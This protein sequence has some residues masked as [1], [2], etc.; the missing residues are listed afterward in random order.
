MKP[1]IYAH[2]GASA[3]APENTM[4]AFYEAEKRGADGIELDVQMTK[5]G[6]LVVL[7]DEDVART[8]NGRGLARE[9]TLSQLRELDFG[10]WFGPA[11]A[12]EKIPTLWQVLE[13]L[14]GN[15]LRQNIE[16][17]TCSAWYDPELTRR[18]VAMV[19]QSGLKD[20]VIFSSFEHRCLLDAKEMDPSIPA[21]LL[22]VGNLIGPGRYARSLGME[23]IHP[24]WDNLD[25]KGVADC[26]ENG[27][28]IH[29]WTIND[30]VSRDAMLRVGAEHLITNYPDILER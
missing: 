21:G 14:Q 16:L 28:E 2:R 10:S 27:I 5:D 22:Y 26:R 8:S 15:R 7:H 17:K 20:R 3:Y 19:Q 1:L 18:T 30:A 11:W 6:V 29:P 24:C 12:G 9:M 13:F 4:A 23:Y 25:E